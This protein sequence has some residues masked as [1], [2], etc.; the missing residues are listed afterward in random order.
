MGAGAGG[1]HYAAT[2]N[3]RQTGRGRRPRESSADC[4]RDLKAPS[5]LAL[6]HT[7][8]V[9]DNRPEGK[10]PR[11]RVSTVFGLGQSR[12]S[13]LPFNVHFSLSSLILIFR[14]TSAV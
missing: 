8:R 5:A 6:M 7:K 14:S 4:G 9:R 3:P 10:R 13:F 11:T 12:Q 1:G 2:S